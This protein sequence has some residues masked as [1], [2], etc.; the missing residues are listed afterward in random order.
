MI[1]ITKLNSTNGLSAFKLPKIE[2]VRVSRDRSEYI[3]GIVKSF[4]PVL[5]KAFKDNHFVVYV[6]WIGHRIVYVGQSCNI[7]SRLQS[8]KNR[9]K[10]THVSLLNFKDF[11]TMENVEKALIQK[12]KPMFNKKWNPLKLAN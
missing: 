6:L 1:N 4:K 11:N 5:K 7:Y 3:G 2:R 9:I 12:H 8:H 10:Y